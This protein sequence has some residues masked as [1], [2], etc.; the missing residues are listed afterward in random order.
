MKIPAIFV[1]SNKRSKKSVNSVC[2]T[3]HVHQVK[4]DRGTELMQMLHNGYSMFF[5]RV[6]V[7]AASRVVINGCMY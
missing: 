1:S 3:P 4:S 6:E 2:F 5:Q 7:P